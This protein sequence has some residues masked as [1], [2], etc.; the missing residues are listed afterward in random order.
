[1]INYNLKKEKKNIKKIY[2]IAND[3]L[4]TDFVVFEY[5]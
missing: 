5:F 4:K 1:M 3:K 2:Q